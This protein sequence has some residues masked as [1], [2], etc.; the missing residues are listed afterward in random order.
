MAPERYFSVDLL[1]WGIVSLR[2]EAD[3]IFS[4]RAVI[5]NILKRRKGKKRTPGLVLASPRQQGARNVIRV[6]ADVAC[7]AR[8]QNILFSF[9]CHH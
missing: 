2:G 4:V 1:E 5:T 7:R 3:V 6:L 8:K 9:L